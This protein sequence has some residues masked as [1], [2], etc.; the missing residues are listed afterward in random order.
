M[1]SMPGASLVASAV[2]TPPTNHPS[3]AMGFGA[4]VF[5][6]LSWVGIAP[7]MAHGV[8]ATKA[9]NIFA[10]FTFPPLASSKGFLLRIAHVLE[11]CSGARRVQTVGLLTLQ[12]QQ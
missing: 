1:R 2:H 7:N 11:S 6:A 10:P 4:S 8:S 3:A 5:F 12:D 9:R